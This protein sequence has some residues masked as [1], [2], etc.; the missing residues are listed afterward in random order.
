M[1]SR[2][3]NSAA[4]PEPG[5]LRDWPVIMVLPALLAFLGAAVL[6]PWVVM[7]LHPNFGMT[8]GHDT[9]WPWALAVIGVVAFWLTRLM[10]RRNVDHR[11]ATPLL[12]VLGLVALGI[13]MELEPDYDFTAVMRNPASLV[14]AQGYMIPAMIIGLGVWIQA[15]RTAMDTSHLAPEVIRERVVRSWVALIVAIILGSVVNNTIG[16]DGVRQAL[17]ALPVAVI[18]GVSAVALAEF[19]QTRAIARERGL[20]AP[21]WDRWTRVFGGTVVALLVVTLIGLV[22]IGP[23]MLAG[24]VGG[25]KG[26]F[27]LFGRALVLVLYAIVYVLYYTYRGIAWLLSLL[28]IHLGTPELP[29]MNRPE[30]GQQQGP[31]LPEQEDPSVIPYLTEIKWAALIFGVIL[32]GVIVWYLSH[33]RSSSEAGEPID[34]DRANVFSGAL[35]RN[36]IRDFF[37]R[38]SGAEKPRTLNLAADPA[39][40]REAM[41]F[42][43]VLAGRRNLGRADDETPADFASRLAREWP[44]VNGP[45]DRLRA[46]YERVRYGETE[47]DRQQ[48]VEAWRAI[49]H[50]V[51]PA[52]VR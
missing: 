22:I 10:V 21:G 27:S 28:G 8:A 36:Q 52:E 31:M 30:F 29:Q 3:F 18:C 14:N 13:W 11:I 6:S 12:I 5:W 46:T 43:Q 26:L 4:S 35:L 9:P 44:A 24:V 47:E 1:P 41:L 16:A 34:E 49:R 20:T 39:S 37:R 25:L 51:S 40:V 48:A 38:G 19:R 23:G 17:Q 15:I 2:T 7:V 45:L 42:L 50:H 33:H 32:A